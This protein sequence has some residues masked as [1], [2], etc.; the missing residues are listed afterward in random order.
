MADGKKMFVFIRK[1]YEITGIYPHQTC[2]YNW[3]NS[4]ELLFMSMMF[5]ASTAFL[6]FQA[7]SFEEYGS[8]FY[9]SAAA[10]MHIGCLPTIIPQA[11]DIFAL[12]NKFEEF[13]EKRN[14]NKRQK[15]R[16]ETKG[17]WV[18]LYYLLNVPI[19]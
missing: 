10:L 11:D 12:M 15:I 16:I 5:V 14:W 2:S 3:R 8:S 9:I 17:V 1:S 19:K 13:V 7:N 4:T 6:L 18:N